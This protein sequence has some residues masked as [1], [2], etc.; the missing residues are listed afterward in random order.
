MANQKLLES[1]TINDAGGVVQMRNLLPRLKTTDYKRRHWGFELYPCGEI[2]VKNGGMY[3]RTEKEIRKYLGL[4]ELEPGEKPLPQKQKENTMNSPT[5]AKLADFM[6]MHQ[7]PKKEQMMVF[8]SSH[9]KT[10][11]LYMPPRMAG[12]RFSIIYDDDTLLVSRDEKDGVKAGL[13]TGADRSSMTFSKKKWLGKNSHWPRF[14]MLQQEIE[15]DGDSF[16]YKLTPDMLKRYEVA[17]PPQQTMTLHPPA[18]PAPMESR[19]VEAPRERAR[20]YI[21][22]LNQFCQSEGYNIVIENKALVL[23][24]SD[25]IA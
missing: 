10:L 12:L 1:Y 3:A 6:P 16:E 22:W 25:R 24:R 13:V 19:M 8:L 14:N 9:D 4:N 2:V 18:Q 20:R 11:T 23:E 17:K 7:T 5:V 15:F 21:Q